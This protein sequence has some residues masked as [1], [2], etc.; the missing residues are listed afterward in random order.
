MKQWLNEIGQTAGQAIDWLVAAIEGPAEDDDEI[1][2][3]IGVVQPGPR[4]R[5]LV[6]VVRGTHVPLPP[7]RWRPMGV[8]P[9]PLALNSERLDEAYPTFA[10]RSWPEWMELAEAADA[11]LAAQRQVR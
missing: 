10:G 5:D 1:D 2:Q 7:G 11:A 9:H 6:L 3:D 8:D 4:L